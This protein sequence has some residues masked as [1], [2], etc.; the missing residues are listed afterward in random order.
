MCAM[1]LHVHMEM[2]STTNEV[3]EKLECCV[4]K[5]NQIIS[6]TISQVFSRFKQES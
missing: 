3:K 5:R 2:E 6:N 1:H 4:S